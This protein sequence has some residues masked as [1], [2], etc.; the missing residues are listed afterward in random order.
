MTTVSHRSPAPEVSIPRL[1]PPLLTPPVTSHTAHILLAACDDDQRL[2]AKLDRLYR[3][4][5][6]RSQ[7]LTHG[8]YSAISGSDLR[9]LFTLYDQQFFSGVLT[10]HL[11]QRISFTLSTR[12]TSSAGKT[13]FRKDPVRFEIRLSLP[14]LF[15]TFADTGRE[16]EVLV[17]GIPCH[18]RL[19]ATLR[20]FEHELVHLIEFML[21]GASRCTGPL[22][23]QLSWNLF[24]HTC[25]T[26]QLTT[27]RERAARVLGL[28]VGSRV[29]FK[30]KGRRLE[31][32]IYRIT[33]RATVMVPDPEGPYVDAQRRRYAKYYVPLKRLAPVR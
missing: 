27:P 9:L 13:L 3:T 14:L 1:S 20:V 5:L 6:L 4:V 12:M 2:A 23:K 29:S 22:F 32:T 31:G 16:R 25:Q 7:T 30:T 10:H 18:D 26:H 33:K 24:R 21:F 17:N 28:T 19:E 8:N 11:D 15:G